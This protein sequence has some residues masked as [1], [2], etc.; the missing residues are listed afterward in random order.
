[1]PIFPCEKDGKHGFKWGQGGNCIIRSTPEEAKKVVIRQG[2]KI[3]GPD[4]FAKIMKK[5]KGWTAEDKAFAHDILN[6][7]KGGWYSDLTK[8][9]IAEFAKKSLEDSPQVDQFGNKK[10]KSPVDI[11]NEQYETTFTTQ[12]KQVETMEDQEENAED[13]EGENVKKP[14]T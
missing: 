11:P 7:S 1:M 3:E 4:K 2:I 10:K 8:Q 12:A 13:L 9:T 14:I 6:E 5:E